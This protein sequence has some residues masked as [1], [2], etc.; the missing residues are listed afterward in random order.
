MNQIES[1]KYFEIFSGFTEKELEPI[2]TCSSVMEFPKDTLIL[3]ECEKSDD[4]YILLK[5]R[6]SVELE[7]PSYMA[8]KQTARLSILKAGQVFGEIAFLTGKLRF[9]QKRCIDDVR[10]LIINADNVYKIFKD[11]SLIGF[12]MMRN[13]AI[14][15]CDRLKETNLMWRN[16]AISYMR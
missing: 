6:V 12:K 16:K 5:G 15:S 3:K 14:V 2:V 13:L 10:V 8:K 1:L 9:A 4:L 11:D 7:M